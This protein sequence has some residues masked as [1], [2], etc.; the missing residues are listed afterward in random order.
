MNVGEDALVV[1]I[2][3]NFLLPVNNPYITSKWK[4]QVLLSERT[5]Q[6]IP[7]TKFLYLVRMCE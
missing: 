2:N 7:G 3:F 6:S 1:D 4:D 5:T